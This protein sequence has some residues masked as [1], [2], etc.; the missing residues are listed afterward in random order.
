MMRLLVL[1]AAVAACGG[2]KDTHSDAK[3]EGF[4]KPDIVCPGGPSCKTTGDGT[5]S[6]GA[7]KRVYTPQGFET[8]TDENM[9][10][11]YQKGEPF[12]DLNGNGVFDGVWL[13][14]GGRAAEAVTTD[15]EVRAMAF[16]EGDVTVVIAYVDCIGL[17][18]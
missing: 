3:L 6:V 8:Y 14:G 10:R 9:D 17:L 4:D 16:I 18:A 12:T 11:Q 1:G 2:T 7:A 13:F 15:V 5:L